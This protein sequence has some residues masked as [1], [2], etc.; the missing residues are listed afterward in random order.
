MLATLTICASW[1]VCNMAT[2]TSSGPALLTSTQILAGLHVAIC[3]MLLQSAQLFRQHK[4][5]SVPAC[6]I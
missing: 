1:A 4:G 3:P 5:S 6:I 2:V